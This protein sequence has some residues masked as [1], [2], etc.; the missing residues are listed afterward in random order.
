[1]WLGREQDIRLGIASYDDA[2][3]GFY[4]AHGYSLVGSRPEDQTT[5]R[6]TGKV[7][8]ETLL[9]RHRENLSRAKSP[10]RGMASN[11]ILLFVAGIAVYDKL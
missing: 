6:A 10:S 5:V 9:V 4:T 11:L 1:M 7:I 3:L 8:H 2:T